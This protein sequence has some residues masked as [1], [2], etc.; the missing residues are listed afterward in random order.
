MPQD[1][2]ALAARPFSPVCAGR[3]YSI[4]FFP[5]FLVAKRNLLSWLFTTIVPFGFR[6]LMRE[7][8]SSRTFSGTPKNLT[9]TG[10]SAIAVKTTMSTG[11]HFAMELMSPGWSAPISRTRIF[12]KFFEWA[13]NIRRLYFLTNPVDFSRHLKVRKLPK[14]RRFHY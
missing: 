10:M 12:G 3:P 8:F 1:R 13:R 5:D 14:E 4:N 6:A 9:W 11:S 7:I 2:R